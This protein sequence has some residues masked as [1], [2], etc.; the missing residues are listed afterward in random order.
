[1]IERPFGSYAAAEDAVDWCH[2]ESVVDSR[3]SDA[4]EAILNYVHAVDQRL[5]D[6]KDFNK[7]GDYS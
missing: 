6:I 2:N 3:V 1:M 4:L 7:L 5:Q